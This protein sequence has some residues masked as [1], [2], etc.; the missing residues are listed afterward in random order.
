MTPTLFIFYQS[1]YY[2]YILFSTTYKVLIWIV[3]SF[4]ETLVSN[5]NFNISLHL[6]FLLFLKKKNKIQSNP[7]TAKNSKSNPNTA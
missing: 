1:K 4:I 3:T 5:Y 7:N 6:L 2:T